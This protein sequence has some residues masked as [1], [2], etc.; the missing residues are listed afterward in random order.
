[1]PKAIL[2]FQLPEEQEDFKTAQ[3]AVGYKCALQDVDNKFRALTKYTETLPTSWAEVRELFH[4][5]LK[6]SNCPDIW[7]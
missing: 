2:E 6:E 7:E 5:V 4:E 3:N 1:M